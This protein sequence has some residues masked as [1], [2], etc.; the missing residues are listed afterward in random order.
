MVLGGTWSA[1]MLPL[2]GHLTRRLVAVERAVLVHVVSCHVVR[3]IGVS[4]NPVF[5]EIFSEGIDVQL[6]INYFI[7]VG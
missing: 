5:L 2:I 4:G 3:N 7:I 1:Q 6:I